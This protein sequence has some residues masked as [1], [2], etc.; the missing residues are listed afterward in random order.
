MAVVDPHPW[1]WSHHLWVTLTDLHDERAGTTREAYIIYI[2]RQHRAT[3][4]DQAIA[5]SIDGFKWLKL[6]LVYANQKKV[7]LAL[8]ALNKSLLLPSSKSLDITYLFQA[9]VYAATGDSERAFEKY[10][11]AYQANPRLAEPYLVFGENYIEYKEY[12]R[13][14]AIF[15]EGLRRADLSG[16][17]GPG[18][19]IELTYH[20]ALVYER[21]GKTKDALKDYKAILA[22][23]TNLD[24]VQRAEMEGQIRQLEQRN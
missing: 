3:T 17:D 8:E 12:N 24:P 20:R 21:A 11:N 1:K 23:S 2:F 16:Q 10:Q 15:S 22:Q 4:E 6:A 5:Q 18:F 14:I 7:T 13:A 19:K 9:R